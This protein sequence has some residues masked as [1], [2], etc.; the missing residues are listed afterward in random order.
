MDKTTDSADALMAALTDWNH[1]KWHQ[2]DCCESCHV[3]D[4]SWPCP[5]QQRYLKLRPLAEA[6]K[7]DRDRLRE[8]LD[9]FGIPWPLDGKV[10]QQQYLDDPE[11]QESVRRGLVEFGALGATKETPQSDQEQLT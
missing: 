10:V 6:L 1:E 4:E 3:C 9:F 7:A 11:L 8:A 5:P 2:P